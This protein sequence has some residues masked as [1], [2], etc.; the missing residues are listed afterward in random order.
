MKPE[1]IEIT[2][3]VLL[4]A[5]LSGIESHGIAIMTLY[6]EKMRAGILQLQ[7]EPRIVRQNMVTALIDAGAGLGHTASVMATRL[8]TEKAKAN[9]IGA[10]SVTNSHHFGIAGYYAKMIADRGLERFQSRYTL[11]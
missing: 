2:A 5:D 10:V 1:M 11:H 4:A 3:D 8:A 6:E 7:A 9:G